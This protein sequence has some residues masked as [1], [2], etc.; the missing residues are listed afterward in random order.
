M[1]GTFAV[2][3]EAGAAPPAA[4]AVRT[5]GGIDA[6]MALQGEQGPAE[7]RRRAVAKGRNALDALEALRVGVLGG[8]VAPSALARLKSAAAELALATGDARLDQI[9]AEIELR[10]EVELAKFAA[11]NPAE[12]CPK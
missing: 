3:N 2:G 7:R 12:N 1:A 9:I 11:A 10:V 8:S 6:L 5:I 4:P